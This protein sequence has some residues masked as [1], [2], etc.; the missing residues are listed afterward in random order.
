MTDTPIITG[1]RTRAVN[2]PLEYPVRTSVGVVATS[3]LVLIDIE[4]DSAITGRAYV[5]TYTP[6]ALK[7]TRVLVE[8]IGGSLVGEPVAP[9]E[10]YETLSR[11]L[12][13]LGRT[14][15]ATMVCAGIDM[16]L[17]DALAKRHDVPLVTL[18][19]GIPKAIP[20]YDSHSMDGIEIGIQRAA[21]AM[22]GGYRAIKTKIGYPSLAQDLEIIRAL[23][24][25]VGPDVEIFV[26]YNQSLSVPE[27]SRRIDA[28][29]EEGIGWVEEPTLQED[30]RG[31]AAIRDR[32]RV[33]IQ[34]GENWCEPVDMQR[35]LTA[36]A[37]DLAM[38]D[39][40]KIG[41][42]TG[43]LRAASLAQSAGI[44]LSSHIFQEVSVHLLAVTPTA[45]WLERMDLAG[46]I[47]SSPSI[48]VD[49]NARCPQVPGI[50][51]A[52]N[53]DA[54]RKYSVT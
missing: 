31:H 16:A 25:V 2:V 20:A 37:C 10:I 33:P 35:A 51:M 28:L 34:M 43:W 47:L 29:T 13:L 12:R 39:A 19:G 32:S 5:F 38:V 4:T 15:L 26:D 27:A 52:W 14:G 44:P 23:R 9:V 21:R 54:V 48:F 42:V 41:G 7:A 36:G 1:V 11:R 49:G 17:W 8:S 6:L 40:M 45:H 3:P 24:G 22:D 53:E 50:G 18:L 30:L 46:P